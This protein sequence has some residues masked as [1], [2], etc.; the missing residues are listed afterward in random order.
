MVRS[1][2][3]GS[4][5]SLSSNSPFM[6]VLVLLHHIYAAWMLREENLFN[7]SH[8]SYCRAGLS[9]RMAEIKTSYTQ[10]PL[11]LFLPC[12][13]LLLLLLPCLI[14]SLIWSLPDQGQ[15]PAQWDSGATGQTGSAGEGEPWAQAT[16]EGVWWR[17]PCCST[18]K[19]SIYF[20]CPV[21][22]Q[23]HMC[24]RSIR[25][26]QWALSSSCFILFLF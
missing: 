24:P 17:R 23:W 20:K 4:W 7:F 13:L 18:D 21:C 22:L 11:L 9:V 1:L 15:T 10:W 26:F 8:T 5:F 2:E 3:G 6:C 12:L 16:A 14:C 25:P 19:T